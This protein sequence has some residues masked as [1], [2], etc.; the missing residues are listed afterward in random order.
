MAALKARPRLGPAKRAASSGLHGGLCG[1][2]KAGPAHLEPA[3]GAV[4]AI[5]EGGEVAE[6]A[7][8]VL[9]APARALSTA[10]RPPH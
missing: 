3:V 2:A 4:Q 1:G 7:V 5:P 6:V 10:A 9:V 8:E